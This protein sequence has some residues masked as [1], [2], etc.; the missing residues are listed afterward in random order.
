MIST[1]PKGVWKCPNCICEFKLLRTVKRHA[2][3]DVECYEEI[4]RLYSESFFDQSYQDEAHTLALRNMRTMAESRLQSHQEEEVVP[5]QNQPEEDR[6]RVDPPGECGY[7]DYYGTQDDLGSPSS[8]GNSPSS[9]DTDD[10]PEDVRA[11]LEIMQLHHHD[12]SSSSSEESSSS[13]GELAISHVSLPPHR[14][15]TAFTPFDPANPPSAQSSVLTG[16][17][18]YQPPLSSWETLADEEESELLEFV[19]QLTSPNQGSSFPDL[20]ESLALAEPNASCLLDWLKQTRSSSEFGAPLDTLEQRLLELLELVTV[21]G[22]PMS[23]F[24]NVLKW[25]QRF[26]RNL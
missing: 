3:A 22:V 9:I 23:M 14:I 11:G 6:P 20:P 15:T 19:G 13:E 4:I 1:K 21:K 16:D 26:P 8:T 10:L 18:V 17:I 24:D 5:P 25:A 2:N 12:A 7:I